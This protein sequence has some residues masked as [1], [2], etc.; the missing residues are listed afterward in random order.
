M[1]EAISIHIKNFPNRQKMISELSG[2]T[3]CVSI[4]TKIMDDLLV[5]EQ[6][7]KVIPAFIKKCRS[8]H[9]E[10]SEWDKVYSPEEQLV[11]L[12]SLILFNDTSYENYSL[13]LIMIYRYAA[14]QHI[15]LHKLINKYL[16]RSTKRV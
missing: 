1:L 16:K 14:N 4:I 13:L 2:Q 3:S 12:I 9:P 8:S 5:R 6:T 11:R 7:Q 15:F 10:F